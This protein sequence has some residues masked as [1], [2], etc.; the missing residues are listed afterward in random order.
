MPTPRLN[1]RKC[2]Q[3]GY[4]VTGPYSPDWQFSPNSDIF[5]HY[6]D[7][8]PRACHYLFLFAALHAQG[9]V[10]CC[11]LVPVCDLPNGLG[12]S[13]DYGRRTAAAEA[14]DGEIVRLVGV[15]G[16]VPNADDDAVVRKV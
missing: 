7:Q 1:P 6:G 3:N 8:L 10:A 4:L 11:L 14:L 5:G 9:R 2:M 15:F 12:Q 13:V 16:G